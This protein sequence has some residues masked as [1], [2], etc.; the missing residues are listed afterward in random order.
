MRRT[1]NKTEMLIVED[2]LLLLLDD[3]SGA[4]T[5][6]GALHFPLGG[7]VLAE[8]ELAGKVRTEGTTVFYGPKVVAIDGDPPSDPLLRAA[9]KRVAERP[10]GAQ[11]LLLEIG[12]D[13]RTQ[14]LDRL[15]A[16]DL[17]RRESKRT[18]GIFR[19]TRLPANDPRYE[20][21]LLESVRAVLED[22][23]EPDARGAALVALLSSTGTLP[24]FDPRITWSSTVYTR[25]KELESGN[26]A[27]EAVSVAMIQTAAAISIGSAIA[28]RAASHAKN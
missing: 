2:L 8:L 5:G 17:I 1:V 23:V 14:V 6:E 12:S 4:I 3:E 26:W 9:Y 27:A 11:T 20:A 13:L 22:G 16:R 21:D 7:A 18:L 28:G 24:Q 10:R 25:G 19:T 15:V